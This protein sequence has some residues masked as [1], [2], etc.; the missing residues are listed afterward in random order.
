MDACFFERS[1]MS[2][3]EY[4]VRDGNFPKI[5]YSEKNNIYKNSENGNTSRPLN[6]DEP[7]LDLKDNNRL[8]LNENNTE[9]GKAEELDNSIGGNNEKVTSTKS[10][11]SKKE[12]VVGQHN[13]EEQKR[14]GDIT[15]QK[16]GSTLKLNNST[17]EKGVDDEDYVGKGSTSKLDK[18]KSSKTIKSVKSEKSEKSVKSIKSEK[19]EVKSEK[20]NENGVKG[21]HGG[22]AGKS[23]MG[24]GVN[25]EAKH[26]NEERFDDIE[27]IDSYNN[28]NNNKNND[29]VMEAKQEEHIE[30]TP[31]SSNKLQRKQTTGLQQSAFKGNMEE[32]TEHQQPTVGTNQNTDDVV[33]NN[34]YLN[35]H[36][37]TV[38][39]IPDRKTIEQRIKNS[40][41]TLHDYDRLSSE[42]VLKHD[43]R[44]FKKYFQDELLRNHSIYSIIMK[45]SIEDPI[46]IRVFKLFILLLMI[47]GFNAVT[48]TDDYIDL[49][50][51]HATVKFI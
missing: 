30:E 21:G 9:E 22:G 39:I 4:F 49:L 2:I 7:T 10:L 24:D 42:E 45:Y 41:L 48:Y 35:E 50:A 16:R 8:R 19:S 40:I 38:P 33:I 46:F 14:L 32:P 11:K 6:I 51:M 37:T 17:E 25:I 47:Y 43:R 5:Q 29:K 27:D 13:V 1:Y 26:E 23:K 31:T 12:E 28:N 36:N 15:G 3:E 44:D 20:S 34:N 18:H